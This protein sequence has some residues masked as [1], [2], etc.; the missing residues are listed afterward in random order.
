MGIVD[1]HHIIFRLLP[2]L[3]LGLCREPGGKYPHLIVLRQGLHLVQDKYTISWI[4]RTW[5]HIRDN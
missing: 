3:D 5:E 1:L 2:H 4:L